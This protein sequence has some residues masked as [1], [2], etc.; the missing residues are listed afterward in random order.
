MSGLFPKT[1]RHRCA[2]S[3]QTALIYWHTS[4]HLQNKYDMIHANK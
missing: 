3:V 1:P 2:K 4:V